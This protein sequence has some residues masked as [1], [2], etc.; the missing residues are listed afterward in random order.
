V[1]HRS[2]K[3]IVAAS[4]VAALHARPA[5]PQSS[6]NAAGDGSAAAGATT[7]PPAP[8]PNEQASPEESGWKGRVSRLF[9]GGDD[10]TFRPTVGVVVPGSGVSVGAELERARLGRLGIGAGVD[11]E[12]SIH[13]YQQVAARVGLLGRRRRMSGLRSADAS[14]TSMVDVK[15]SDASGLAVFLEHRYSRLPSL[16]LF[17]RDS[18]GDIVRTDF[19]VRE[20]TTDVVVQWQLTPSFGVGGRVGRLRATLFPGTNDSLPNSEDVFTVTASDS[21]RQSTYVTAG[22]GAIFDRRD[23]P[24]RPTAGGLVSA[25]LWRYESRSQPLSS[26]SRVAFGAEQYRIVGSPRHVVAARIGGSFDLTG[27]ED[28]D[29]VPFYLMQSLGGS[30]SMRSLHSYRLRGGRLVYGIVESR[31]TMKKWLEI[32]PF[33][34]ASRVSRTPILIG[35]ERI[36]VSPGIGARIVFKERVVFRTDVATGPEGTRFV[37]A[38][39]PVF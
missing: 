31:W 8:A 15:R 23:S 12:W 36:L 24:K 6:G 35:T 33:V 11:G 30:H 34:D 32:A 13:N 10:Q 22:L 1:R 27:D 16:G 21:T 20:S 19:G 18:A 17:G 5:S 4:I 3:L 14:L 37:F 2:H 39:D 25:V 29:I 28:E 9:D 7:A 26:F 38:L